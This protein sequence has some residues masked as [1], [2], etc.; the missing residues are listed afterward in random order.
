MWM[1]EYEPLW[2]SYG[3]FSAPSIN[4]AQA[5]IAIHACMRRE[6]DDLSPVME[7]LSPC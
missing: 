1:G 3:D 6:D 2:R 7:C 5:W 4:N